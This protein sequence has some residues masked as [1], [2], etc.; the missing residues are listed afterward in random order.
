[1]LSF[2]PLI[3]DSVTTGLSVLL[4]KPDSR[5]PKTFLLFVSLKAL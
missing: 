1:M 5:L 2:L 4:L 3:N